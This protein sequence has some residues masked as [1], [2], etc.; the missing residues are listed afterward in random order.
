MIRFA[1]AVVNGVNGLIVLPDDWVGTNF[2]LASINNANT[3]FT[4]NVVSASDWIDIL[5]PKGA[6]FLPAAGK[7]EGTTLS[8]LGERGLYWSTTHDTYSSNSADNVVFSVSGMNGY[9][10]STNTSEYRKS[11]ISV[12][13][14]HVR[15]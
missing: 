13:L 3:S 15:E 11:G 12:R 1:K 5:E 14:V 9:S 10:S 8:D 4:N 2:V 7:R 6:V